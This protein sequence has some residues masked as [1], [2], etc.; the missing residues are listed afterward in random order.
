MKFLIIGLGNIG[1][2]YEL[3]RHNIGFLAL[4]K[5]ADEKGFKFVVERHAFLKI[6]FDSALMQADLK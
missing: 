4:Y 5:L 1:P 3:T 6:I 2:E